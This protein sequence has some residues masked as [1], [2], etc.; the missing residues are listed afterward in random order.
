MA[1]KK[2]K[3]QLTFDIGTPE[4]VWTCASCHTGG[5]PYE[6]DRDGNRLDEV[7]PNSVPPLDGD[8]YSYTT[9]E[10]AYGSWGKPHKFD[11][12]KSGSLEADCMTC[13]LDPDTKRVTDATGIKVVT[14]N[15]RI[16]IFA[17]RVKGKVTEVS[18]GI[19][20]DKG[21]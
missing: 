21:W 11:W 7:D 17:K 19:Y 15:P 14:Y 10:V 2:N 8:Y 3:S 16:R 12:R 9:D 18:L 6:Y 5:G 20:P 13:H 4:E 1:A